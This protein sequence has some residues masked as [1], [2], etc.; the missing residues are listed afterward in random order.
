MEILDF[1]ID[2]NLFSIEQAKSMGMWPPGDVVAYGI[3]PYVGRMKV[4]KVKVLDVGVMK[5][6]NAYIMLELDKNQKIEKI[7]GVEINTNEGF[8]KL[9]RENLKGEDRFALWDGEV[10]EGFD[11]VC[12]NSQTPLDEVLPL[13]YNMVKSNG[14]FC[15]NDHALPHVKDALHKFRRDTKIGT[16]ISVSRGSW[17]WWKR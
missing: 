14:I 12:I 2:P 11:V 1:T 16:P 5:G 9:V 10:H 13:Y 7:F 8:E 6:E 3:M 4:D 15:G 17:F